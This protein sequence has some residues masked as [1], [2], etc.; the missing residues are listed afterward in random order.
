MPSYNAQQILTA[1]GSAANSRDLAL[2][3]FGGNVLVAY[4]QTTLFADMANQ[5]IGVKQLSGAKSEQYPILGADPESEE[6]VPG[7]ELLGQ[8]QPFGEQIVTIDDFIVGHR[9]IAGDDQMISHFDAVAPY[10]ASI[11]RQ[12]AISK[13]RKIVRMAIKGARTAASSG[14]HNG[15]NVVNRVGAGTTIADAYP[16][17]ATGAANLVADIRTLA[18]QMDED[19]VP[20]FGR[21]LVL[22]PYAFAV[23]CYDTTNKIFSKD[24]IEGQNSILNRRIGR[25][26]GF[27]LYKSNNSIPSTNLV[28]TGTRSDPDKYD[29]DCRYVAG[30][31]AASTGQPVAVAFCG[32]QD[33]NPGLGMVIAENMYTHLRYIPER[34]GTFMMGRNFLGVDKLAVWNLGVIQGQLS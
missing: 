3:V 10:A 26:E 2:E 31:V 24:F 7:D 4:R 33:G 25:L 21:S 30:N 32:A 28:N 18:R 11:G 19:E 8:D 20:E 34:G 17:S 15:G 29:V 23:L 12:L 13:D 5:L 27:D 9:F 14:F 6:H 22:T 1:S 16:E